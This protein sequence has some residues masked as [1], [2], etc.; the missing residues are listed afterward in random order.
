MVYPKRNQPRWAAKA[1]VGMNNTY[2]T[3]VVKPGMRRTYSEDTNLS[4]TGKWSSSSSASGDE[5]W[6]EM[7]SPPMTPAAGKTKLSGEAE[8][9]VP[10]QSAQGPGEQRTR[11]SSGASVFVPG[12]M[13]SQQA[14]PAFSTPMPPMPQASANGAVMMMPQ[15][16]PMDQG[17]VMPFMAPYYMAPDGCYYVAADGVC[18]VTMP[19]IL[20][21]APPQAP[22]GMPESYTEAIKEPEQPS[23]TQETPS[24]KN[25]PF[26]GN[27]K[28][29][30]NASG[31]SRW[32]DLDDDDDTDNP[33]L[34]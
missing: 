27:Q 31:K 25:A 14:G 9:F 11:L 1:S 15:M 21:S 3:E 4:E 20:G 6:S 8:L 17:N 5:S 7:S 13:A 18:P 2:D 24:M 30:S 26:I 16:T 28:S 10:Q 23:M 19:V 32:A 34:Q 12:Q 22:F 29:P 33:W